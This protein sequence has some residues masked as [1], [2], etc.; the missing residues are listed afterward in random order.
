MPTKRWVIKKVWTGKPVY[1]SVLK[2]FGCHVQSREWS[3]LNPKV[4]KSVYFLVS[5]LV[6]RAIRKSVY[7]LVSRLV[8]R[9]ISYGIDFNEENCQQCSIL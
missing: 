1:C 8:L 5:R 9:A 6:L 2:I 3:K 7:F 4:K